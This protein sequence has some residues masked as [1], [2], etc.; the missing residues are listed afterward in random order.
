MLKKNPGVTSAL[1]KISFDN[2]ALEL[3]SMT[4]NA[5]LGGTTIPNASNSSPVTAYWADNFTDVQGD[6][7]FVTLSFNVSANAKKG[8]YEIVVTYDA[9]DLFNAAEENVHFDVINGKI[10]VS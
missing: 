7:V 4:Y 9:D 2:S 8:D 3:V 1:M 5:E 10:T 6:V